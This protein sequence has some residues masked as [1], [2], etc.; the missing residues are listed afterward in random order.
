M[1][2]EEEKL[3]IAHPKADKRHGFLSLA[4][5]ATSIIFVATKLLLQHQRLHEHEL[6]DAPQ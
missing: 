4:V 6:S 1:E 3:Y 2:K 5:A